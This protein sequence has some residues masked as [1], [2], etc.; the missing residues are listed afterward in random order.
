[1][2]C[3]SWASRSKYVAPN[4]DYVVLSVL[5]ITQL[6]PTRLRLQ[7]LRSYV[8]TSPLSCRRSEAAT[9]L[10]YFKLLGYK[11]FFAAPHY[12]NDVCGLRKRAHNTAIK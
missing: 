10:N 1:M 4:I 8:V 6:I 5:V 7:L 11:S 12:K 3:G 9:D 2:D